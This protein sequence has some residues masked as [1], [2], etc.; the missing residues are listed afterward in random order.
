M[1]QMHKSRTINTEV[2]LTVSTHGQWNLR[3]LLSLFILYIFVCILNSIFLDFKNES[4]QHVYKILSLN[5]KDINSRG[6]ELTRY[7]FFIIIKFGIFTLSYCACS[8]EPTQCSCCDMGQN[9]TIDKIELN[10]S[11]VLSSDNA[12]CK[13]DIQLFH[14]LFDELSVYRDYH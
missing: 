6:L 13:N 11:I 3:N 10:P 7:D 4:L 12:N 1:L 5:S 8:N 9:D 2:A 14:Q